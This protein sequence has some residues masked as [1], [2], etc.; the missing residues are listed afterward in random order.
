MINDNNRERYCLN[1]KERGIEWDD[2][3]IILSKEILRDETLS[4]EAFMVYVAIRALQQGRYVLTSLN[5]LYY[6]LVADCNSEKEQ[7]NRKLREKIRRGF[8][9]LLDFNLIEIVHS[10]LDQF[11][12]ECSNIALY[13]K[14]V[15]KTKEVFVPLTL[16]EIRIIM[17]IPNIQVEKLLRYF[18]ILKSTINTDEGNCSYVA[19]SGEEIIYSFNKTNISSVHIV[20]CSDL[21]RNTLPGGES[22]RM[23]S[24]R[25]NHLLTSP[26][27]HMPKTLCKEFK[28]LGELNG[29]RCEIIAVNNN[30]KRSYHISVNQCFDKLIL[31]PI[32]SWGNDDKIPVISFDFM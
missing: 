3:D 15:K 2:P 9:E 27:M 25:A 4:D 32:S 29:E 14:N 12:L 6:K 19:S 10:A 20:F 22:E 26:Q 16:E 1:V 18:A 24:T 17:N 21:N 11:T 8:D 13:V 30:R 28:L 31:V 23:H 5:Q 7:N